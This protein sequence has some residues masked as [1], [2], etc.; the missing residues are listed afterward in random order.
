[1][2]D[3]SGCIAQVKKT[4][5]ARNTC[6][7]QIIN[8][9]RAGSQIPLSNIIPFKKLDG[10]QNIK[11]CFSMQKEMV[12]RGISAAR[13]GCGWWNLP[14]VSPNKLVQHDLSWLRL[15]CSKIAAKDDE[16]QCMPYRVRAMTMNSDARPRSLKVILKN[17]LDTW[18]WT[19]ED[20]L[21]IGI[22]SIPRNWNL[23]TGILD[24]HET[25]A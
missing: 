5:V 1:M 2:T 12:H 23:V 24:R 14:G 13:S 22:N 6:G 4:C 8:I 17:A 25:Y 20:G 21:F 10:F 7:V 15:F 18:T 11:A 3:K 19:H 9:P 16:W